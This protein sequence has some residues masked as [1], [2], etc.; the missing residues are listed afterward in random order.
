[1]L[2]TFL[3]DAVDLEQER[4]AREGS[5]PP[6]IDETLA[7]SRQGVD[8]G[9]RRSVGDVGKEG[10]TELVVGAEERVELVAELLVEGRPLD[11]RRGRDVSDG[12]R[13]IAALPH[14]IEDRIKDPLAL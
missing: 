7:G 3:A 14:D 5:P 1:V 12:R 2:E 10:P 9:R 4:S 13:R 11:A 8:G 6:P